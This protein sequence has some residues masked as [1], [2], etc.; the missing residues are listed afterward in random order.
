MRMV[1]MGMREMGVSVF[2]IMRVIMLVAVVVIV[3]VIV[4]MVMRMI[5]S[6]IMPIVMPVVVPMIM[7]AIR[8]DSLDMMV[9]ALLAAPDLGFETQNLLAVFAKLAVHLVLADQN[10]LHPFEIGRAS[11]RERV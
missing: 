3:V 5:K 1:G 11:C 6:V 8:A 9:M 10:L 4:M 2:M 7:S